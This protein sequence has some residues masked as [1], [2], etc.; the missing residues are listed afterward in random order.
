[1]TESR[2]T[3]LSKDQT[4]RMCE[5]AEEVARRFI[6]S[7]GPSRSVSDLTIS[8]GL[9]GTETLD[10]EVDVELTLSSSLKDVDAK[11]LA[12]NSVKVAFDAVEKYLRG[13]GCRL[14]K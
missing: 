10:V 5:V 9:E 11:Q 13:T 3:S 8:V 14:E 12:D 2:A 4:E 1:M 7:K 6:M